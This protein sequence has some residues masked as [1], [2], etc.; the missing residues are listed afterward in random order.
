LKKPTSFKKENMGRLQFLERRG[1]FITY[2]LNFMLSFYPYIFLY[3]FGGGG[4][5]WN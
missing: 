4:V 2:P 1:I 3:H 5:F